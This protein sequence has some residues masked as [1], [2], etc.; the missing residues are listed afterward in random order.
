[1]TASKNAQLCSPVA[2]RIAQEVRALPIKEAARMLGTSLPMIRR[3]RS[4]TLGSV[5]ILLKAIEQ[6]GVRVLEPIIGQFDDESLFRRLD[7]IQSSLDEVR[8]ARLQR[9]LSD[10]RAGS[11]LDADVGNR[12][13]VLADRESTGGSPDGTVSV[14]RLRRPIDEI[15]GSGRESLRRQVNDWRDRRGIL[16]IE[17]AVAYAKADETGR[18]GVAIRKPGDRWQLAYVAP[19]NPLPSTI[20]DEATGREFDALASQPKTPWLLDT[21]AT[22]LRNGS[23]TATANWVCRTLDRARDGTGILLAGFAPKTV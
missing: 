9:P 23:V 10:P 3:L 21:G 4:G 14:I 12:R 7:A 20:V 19:A 18:T 1:M 8:H 5:P 11:V 22:F 2:D 17:D 13:L 6:F 15:A 16:S